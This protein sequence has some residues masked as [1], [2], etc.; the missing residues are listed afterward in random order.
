M[1]KI[2]E[3]GSKKALDD[4]LKIG[5]I[6][7]V[8]LDDQIKADFEYLNSF[9]KGEINVVSRTLD[10]QFWMVTDL[11]DLAPIGYYLYDRAAKHA[12]F[13][14]SDRPELEQYA[15]AR[16]TI[17]G[18]PLRAGERALE[19]RNDGAYAVMFLS[20]GCALPQKP[21]RTSDVPYR[22]LDCHEGDASDAKYRGT[23][24]TRARSGSG[25]RR[26]LQEARRIRLWLRH[27]GLFWLAH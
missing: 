4:Q 14:F 11:S 22:K 12:R 23:R 27:N 15:L 18:C 17:A 9:A 26:R 19:R 6:A 1:K 24:Y 10:D 13:L 21:V 16:L 5:A 25:R 7:L 8:V 20:S 3:A 2:K